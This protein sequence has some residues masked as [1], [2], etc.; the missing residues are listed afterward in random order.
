[1]KVRQFFSEAST[2]R[3]LIVAVALAVLL[4]TGAS[5]Q[6]HRETVALQLQAARLRQDM[7][8]VR[9]LRAALLESESA[10]RGYLL[11]GSA[12]YLTR[13]DQAAAVLENPEARRIAARV[14]A[15]RAR[16]QSQP[17]MGSLLRIVAVRRDVLAR[18]QEGDRESVLAEGRSGAPQQ[19]AEAVR[20]AMLGYLALREAE[21]DAVDDSLAEIQAWVLWLVVASALVTLGALGFAGLQ[22]SRRAR[23]A[24]AAREELARRNDEVGGLLRMSDMLQACQNEEDLRRV[25]L[26]TA[27]EVLPGVPGALYVFNNSRDRLDVAAVWPEGTTLA[28]PDHFSPQDCWAL[29]RG[30]P[31]LY[32]PGLGV[33]CDHVANGLPGLDVPMSARGE[34]YGVMQFGCAVA[35]TPGPRPNRDLAVALADGVSMALANLSLR[36][37]LRGQALR[38]PLTGLYNR[39]FLE[40]VSERY[41]GSTERRGASLSVVMVDADH[42]KQVNDR[43]GHAVGDAVLRAL[44]SLIQGALRKGD[45]ACRYG[46]EEILLLLPDCD[47]AAARE[48]MEELRVRVSG[49]HEGT[50]T[51]LP[52]VT[53]SIGI[54]AMPQ[55]ATSVAAAIKRADEALYAAK[56]GGRNQ[57]VMARR[58]ETEDSQP[59]HLADAAAG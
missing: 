1:M 34:V 5:L 15:E 54:A 30:R 2:A 47:P 59:P 32:G 57:V 3:W 42:F 49:L 35:G 9:N 23:S 31:H 48:R 28:G 45:V 26:H 29:K 25:V 4:S 13:F 16:T 50:D 40:E 36:E 18:L 12:P 55:H 10:L 41:A 8:D 39:R 58:P 52:R 46:G 24:M 27:P 19:A 7:L 38:D 51:I 21:A 56:Q 6:G 20:Q 44:G 22:V 53:V 33:P 17:I 37:K 14:D 43:H 11:F